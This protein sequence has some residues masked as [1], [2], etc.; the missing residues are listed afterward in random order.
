MAGR[1]TKGAAPIAPRPSRGSVLVA[2]PERLRRAGVDRR[3]KLLGGG[4][5][6]YV[7]FGL[8]R[9]LGLGDDLG[10]RSD[11]HGR[12]Y[13]VRGELSGDGDLLLDLVGGFGRRLGRLG[14][15][16]RLVDEHRTTARD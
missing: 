2:A 10:G 5:Y 16:G 14:R 4:A 3:R 13:M 7:C 12:S 6:P 9:R 15:L 11:A 1:A 8:G